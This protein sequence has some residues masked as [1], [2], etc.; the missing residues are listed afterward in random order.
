MRNKGKGLSMPK[1]NN[2]GKENPSDSKFCQYCG[3]DKLLEIIETKTHEDKAKNNKNLKLYSTVV[4]VL[5]VGLTI[6]S[7][8]L[9]ISM[10]D[11]YTALEEDYYYLVDISEDW[12]D[13][14]DKLVDLIDR[15]H[16]SSNDYF[17]ADK[18]VLI[19]PITALV[20]VESNFGRAYT[21]T[22]NCDYGVDCEW[23][24]DGN[25]YDNINWLQVSYLGDEVK[26]ISI[27]NNINN[28]TI[29]ILVLGTIKRR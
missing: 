5:L 19:N 8:F 14:S 24:D 3:S 13:N 18:N 25:N 29:N 12:R 1:C 9:I 15:M 27:T 2:C 10:N 16:N 4:T 7:L 20:R 23:L 21:V 22:Y 11:K 26:E 28:E 17:F 6:F